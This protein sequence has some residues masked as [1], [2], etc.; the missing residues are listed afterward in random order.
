MYTSF[1]TVI[2]S[3]FQTF[4]AL[5]LISRERKKHWKDRK[6]QQTNQ[7]K[8]KEKEKEKDKE[9][10][11]QMKKKKGQD[12][13]KKQNL[14]LPPIKK[15]R[16][17]K[18][19]ID[20]D[21]EA[22]IE[23]NVKVYLQKISRKKEFSLKN[24]KNLPNSPTFKTNSGIYNKTKSPS[25]FFINSPTSILP[26]IIREPFPNVSN[27]SSRHIPFDSSSETNI[28]T[29]RNNLRNSN[30][31]YN[32]NNHSNINS[33]SNSNSIESEFKIW[34]I[35]NY[36]DGRDCN[37]FSSMNNSQNL[38]SKNYSQYQTDSL[39]QNNS[40]TRSRS[41]CFDTKTQR[42][43]KKKKKVLLEKWKMYC[44]STALTNSID[45][46]KLEFQ[47]RILIRSMLSLL[48]VLPAQ[49]LFEKQKQSKT[50]RFE[51]ITEMS[52][53]IDRV[54]NNIQKENKRS[55]DNLFSYDEKN[56]IKFCPYPKLQRGESLYTNSRAKEEGISKKKLFDRINLSKIKNGN[57]YFITI[58]VDYLKQ[59]ERYLKYLNPVKYSIP[60]YIFSRKMKRKPKSCTRC[61][62]E[63]TKSKIVSKKMKN[64]YQNHHHNKYLYPQNKNP[65]QIHHRIPRRKHSKTKPIRIRSNSNLL[66]D[67]YVYISPL[68]R[69]F[70][71]TTGNN[72]DEKYSSTNSK[73]LP[74][75]IQV[76]NQIQKDPDQ[77][78]KINPY[79]NWDDSPNLKNK[80]YQ[81][82]NPDNFCQN[83]MMKNNK[84][85]NYLI[86]CDKKCLL[87]NNSMMK[88]NN[89]Y[90]NDTDSDSSDSAGNSNGSNQMGANGKPKLTIFKKKY[91]PS[92]HD[93]NYETENKQKLQKQDK[94]KHQRKN[95]QMKNQAPI[96]T[97]KSEN[98]PHLDRFK[99][100]SEFTLS[101]GDII[102]ELIEIEQNP[103]NY[104]Y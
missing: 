37:A 7:N 82:K 1:I 42:E 83:P 22:S 61:S 75:P 5:I 74:F 84:I 58:Q 94:K 64:I 20:E 95:Y 55:S 13:Q 72:F 99:N 86:S 21:D 15:D 8:D 78:S 51:L 47:L 3:F 89:N 31:D 2:D 69:P 27:S 102:E 52:V 100:F 71:F 16:V 90:G 6:V 80:F 57:F 56:Y 43:K 88:H 11:S 81:K 38:S 68:D 44:S 24:K 39:I 36:V 92:I 29:F 59:I 77:N 10:K 87:I 79:Q 4:S 63:I 30:S 98:P 103:L 49:K 96:K 32:N 85:F 23:V 48:K 91:L 66:R 54:H 53:D 50:L 28:T 34:D 97:L 101:P 9:N 93:I 62:Q 33:N 26:S 12:I 19:N 25:P 40:N 18:L 73:I 67:P 41:N 70:S 14:I 76:L 45:I 46:Q 35:C 104:R 65:Y 17:L 60:N